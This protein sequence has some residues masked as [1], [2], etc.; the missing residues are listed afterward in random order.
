[1]ALIDYLI[2]PFLLERTCRHFEPIYQHAFDMEHYGYKV[3]V[4]GICQ[5]PDNFLKYMPDNHPCSL[6]CPKYITANSE[7]ECLIC[8]KI[9]ADRD[10]Y[11]LRSLSADKIEFT[12]CS[13]DC[14]ELGEGLSLMDPPNSSE[15]PE[16]IEGICS[17]CGKFIATPIN[18]KLYASPQDKGVMEFCSLECYK[19]VSL[20]PDELEEF[21]SPDYCRYFNHLHLYNR[22][23]NL[24]EEF[25]LSLACCHPRHRDSTS[26]EN[27]GSE[28][29]NCASNCPD[30]MPITYNVT[31][32]Y[33]Q[34]NNSLRE[35]E[36]IR[37]RHSL[38]S[39]VEAYEPGSSG[40][41]ENIYLACDH[42]FKEFVLVLDWYGT[43]PL[44]DYDISEVKS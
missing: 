16:K 17:V 2:P 14:L 15:K 44:N 18:E 23:V 7:T 25:K 12:A 3:A 4:S 41:V 20:I 11:R 1:M 19:S 30:Y 39:F 38:L 40:Y 34:G 29:P 28:L 21:R 33:C 37:N 22:I 31:C 42:C 43:F 32:P 24:P 8:G 35:D 13:Q 36:V 6:D 10:I 26:Q 27:T 9:I 5:H